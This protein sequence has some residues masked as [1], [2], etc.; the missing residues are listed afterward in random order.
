MA[1]GAVG[2]ELAAMNIGVA[3]RA[4]LAN[5]G[6]NRPEVAFRAVDFFVLAAKGITS[7]VVAEFR[8][9]A[10]RGPACVRVAVLA[11]NGQS[12]MRTPA[13]LPLRGQWVGTG[14]HQSGEH[15]PETDL[16][17]VRNECPLTF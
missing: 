14:E 8:N 3:V 13:G 4:V 5:V 11:G 17:R 10:N 12:P 6:K 16:E 7:R 1:L 9:G 15:E 2:A